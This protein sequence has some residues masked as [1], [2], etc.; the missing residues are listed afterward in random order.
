MSTVSEREQGMVQWVRAALGLAQ[1]QVYLANQDMPRAPA[2]P[3]V[4]V[5]FGGGRRY[6]TTDLVANNYLPSNP[7]GHEIQMHYQG[8]RAG[9]VYLMAYS[10]F[11]FGDSSA[12]AMLERIEVLAT[13]SPIAASAFKAAGF[14]VPSSMAVVDLSRVDDTAF[15]GQAELG[16]NILYTVEAVEETGYFDTVHLTSTLKQKAKP[17]D[18]DT[19]VSETEDEIGLS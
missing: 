14:S 4:T 13:D 9:V 2:R 6:G 10:D 5:T 11:A 17:P 1:G 7:T 8:P 18:A 19:V 3:Y 16:L 12:K 15:R